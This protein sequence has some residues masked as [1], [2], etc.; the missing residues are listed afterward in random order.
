MKGAPE[1]LP[2][3]W[4]Q[5]RKR[6][7]AQQLQPKSLKETASAGGS[8]LQPTHDYTP[9]SPKV[10]GLNGNLHFRRLQAQD[11]SSAL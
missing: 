2:N 7:V 11:R 9:D 6:Q 1:V 3:A 8:Q 5:H 4:V 10:G